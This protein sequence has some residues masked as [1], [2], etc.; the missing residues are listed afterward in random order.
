MSIIAGA[1]FIYSSQFN[2]PLG[3]AEPSRAWPSR[4]ADAAARF[5]TCHETIRINNSTKIDT[6]ATPGALLNIKM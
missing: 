3:R 6:K 2:S 5:L 1:S 4:A